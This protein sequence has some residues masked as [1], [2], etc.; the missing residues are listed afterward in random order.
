MRMKTSNVLLILILISVL[1]ILATA[2]CIGVSIFVISRRGGG[3]ETWIVP[4]SGQTAPDFQLKS[5]DGEEITLSDFRGKPVMINF[6]AIWCNPCIKEMPI[7][8]DRYLQHYPDLVV[9]AIEEDGKG[10][11]LRDY[12]AESSFSFL[13]LA[14]NDSVAREYNV[15]VY[16][17]SYFID[18]KGVIQSMVVGNLTGP[19]L[20]KELAK[21]GVE[22]K[23]EE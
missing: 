6:W 3:F 7:I 19:T 4:R 21:I 5:I 9:L 12:M 13:V 20:D 22:E 11:A 18:E 23:H 8:Q 16:P 15:H 10:V 14:G 1:C 17:T 2:C